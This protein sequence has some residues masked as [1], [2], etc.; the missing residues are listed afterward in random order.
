MS[1]YR[2]PQV[3]YG[4]QAVKPISNIPADAIKVRIRMREDN[5]VRAFVKFK[6]R[7][8]WWIIGPDGGFNSPHWKL[9]LKLGE[10]R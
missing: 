1:Y 8:E 7:I 6:D 4:I 5:M 9:A 10:N 2:A 3:I